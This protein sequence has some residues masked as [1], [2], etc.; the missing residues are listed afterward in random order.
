[1]DKKEIL[2][3]LLGL[4]ENIT[5]D[6]YM[7]MSKTVTFDS[8]VNDC[9]I[10]M[11]FYMMSSDEKYYQEFIER[12]DKLNEESKELVKNDY[13]NIIN[14]QCENNKIKRKGEMNYE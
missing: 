11:Y 9:L 13:I 4:M 7:S 6:D 14:T 10:Y 5:G 12:F 3:M 8:D 1:M 2:L